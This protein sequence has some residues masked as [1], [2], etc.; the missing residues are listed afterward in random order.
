MRREESY[1][2]F[3]PESCDEVLLITL[4]RF[5]ARIEAAKDAI[6]FECSELLRHLVAG[7]ELFAAGWA[8]LERF[9]L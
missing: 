2:R 7:A 3:G 4:S 5:D 1:Q 8:C 6:A 9:P